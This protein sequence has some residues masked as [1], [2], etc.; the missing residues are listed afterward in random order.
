[1]VSPGNQNEERIFFKPYYTAIAQLA[2][3]KTTQGNGGLTRFLL[4]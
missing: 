4:D 1:M 3:G 2:R